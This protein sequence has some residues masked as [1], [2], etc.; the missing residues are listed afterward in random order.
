MLSNM[1]AGY[2]LKVYYVDNLI[3]SPQALPTES[4]PRNPVSP[5][6]L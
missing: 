1:T 6:N 3:E 2:Y 4:L 5:I